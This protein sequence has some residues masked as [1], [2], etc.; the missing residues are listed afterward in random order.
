MSD[1]S[2]GRGKREK[3]SVIDL[4][5]PPSSPSSTSSIVV[6]RPAGDMCS[7]GGGAGSN[8]GSSAAP[9]GMVPVS[10]DKQ[11]RKDRSKEASKGKSAKAKKPKKPSVFVVAVDDPFEASRT[12]VS[13]CVRGKPLPQQRDRFG[14][15]GNRYNPSKPLQEAFAK[16]VREFFLSQGGVPHFGNTLIGVTASFYL[17]TPKNQGS[18]KNTADVDNLCKFI[19]DSLNGILY[20]DDG[21]VVRLVAEKSFCDNRGGNGY[22]CVTIESRE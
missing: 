4:T 2:S 11:K 17:P 13:F 6:E 10:A 5:S 22:T 9:A 15:N 20:N 1:D 7:S 8:D 14:Y 16:A 3:P 18:I 21:Q 19:L 12:R